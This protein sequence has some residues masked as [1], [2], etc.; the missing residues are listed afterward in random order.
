MNQQLAM[1]FATWAIRCV[2]LSEM[3]AWTVEIF[4]LF[5]R[6]DMATSVPGEIPLPNF[7]GWGRYQMSWIYTCKFK[8]KVHTEA[9]Y[10][11]AKID[12][13]ELGLNHHSDLR[14][15]EG[16]WQTPTLVSSLA[17]TFCSKCDVTFRSQI[18]QEQSGPGSCISRSWV[19][20]LCVLLLN[21]L[22]FSKLFSDGT[23]IFNVVSCKVDRH[24]V[25]V[26]NAPWQGKTCRPLFPGCRGFL[27]PQSSIPQAKGW[28]TEWVRW[29]IRLQTPAI[30]GRERWSRAPFLWT[31]DGSA[32][33][34]LALCSSLA[35]GTQGS[36][37]LEKQRITRQIYLH[38]QLRF[39]NKLWS[40]CAHVP[41]SHKPLLCWKK[42]LL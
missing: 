34:C 6:S 9:Q 26:L 13:G 35:T 8:E 19:T 30:P 15:R 33:E 23:F 3:P 31:L 2:F 22:G 36:P 21:L 40:V 4:T 12:T 41:V 14:R 18:F 5:V 32:G 39:E 42:S 7:F 37:A 25:N 11:L 1:G 20:F 29:G 24:V 17:F 10:S 38:G 16:R 28:C 27:Q